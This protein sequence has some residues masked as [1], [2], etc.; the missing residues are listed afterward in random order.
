MKNKKIAIMAKGKKHFHIVIKHLES[1][2]AINGR[3]FTR[4]GHVSGYYY[5]FEGPGGSIS[6]STSLPKD[7]TEIEL[8]DIEA[9]PKSF[10]T[11][12]KSFP[13][14]MIVWNSEDDKTERM[15][16]QKLDY[17]KEAHMSCTNEQWEDYVSKGIL[18]PDLYWYEFAE[19]IPETPTMTR[20][21]AESKLKCIIT[22]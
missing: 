1:L 5:H 14:R 18:L 22:D 10:T 7:Y 2:G 17:I 15:V 6:C 20:K 21:E 11:K 9:K 16:L 13:R 8:P 4:N 3:N 19:E 12:P